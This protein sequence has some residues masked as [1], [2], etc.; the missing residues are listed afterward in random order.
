MARVASIAM[1]GMSVELKLVP[2]GGGT[3]A[4][5]HR[6]K[7]R[8]LPEYRGAGVTHLLTLLTEPEGAIELGALAKSAGLAWLWCPLEGAATSAS[9]ELVGPALHAAGAAVREGGSL[10]VHC[11]AGI[12]RTGMFGYELLRTLGLDRSTAT[13][14]LHELRATTALGVGEERLRWGDRIAEALVGRN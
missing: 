9:V 13:S 10:V 4:L 11:S 8:D 1:E 3:L 2:V 6:P 14:T 12:H 5:T 7:K